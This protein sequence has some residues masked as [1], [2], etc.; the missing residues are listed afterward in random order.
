[1]KNKELSCATGLCPNII[2]KEV[3]EREISLCKQLSHTNGGKCGWGECA[4]CGVIPL[5]Y[6]LHKGV[7]L[8]DPA[9]IQ[10]TKTQILA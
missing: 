4:S 2:E 8:E 6:K 10:E 7:L 9:A 1:M 3:F 5:L